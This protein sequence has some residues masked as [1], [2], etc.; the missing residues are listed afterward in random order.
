MKTTRYTVFNYTDGIPAFHEGF[1]TRKEAEAWIA[2]F[3]KN[4]NDVQ[5]YYLTSDRERIPLND[6]QLIVER[7]DE[8]VEHE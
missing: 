3:R 4:M 7:I 2:G 6:V 5:G 1:S 8:E